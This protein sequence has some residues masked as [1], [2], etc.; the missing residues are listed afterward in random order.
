MD[1]TRHFVRFI[2]LCDLFFLVF[3]S[4][5]VVFSR[6]KKSTHFCGLL[7]ALVRS[8][9]DVEHQVVRR[10]WTLVD[11]YSS[12]VD[13]NPACS[14]EKKRK[15]EVYSTWSETQVSNQ[16]SLAE[17]TSLQEI[18]SFFIYFRYSSSTENSF[19]CGT[20]KWNPEKVRFGVAKPHPQLRYRII[21]EFFILN[22]IVH[23]PQS[24]SFLEIAT[25]IPKVR[26]LSRAPE[27]D[28]R[29]HFNI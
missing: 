14:P 11:I 1:H 9:E 18:T 2:W 25:P 23:E 16:T 5:G 22:I 20:L 8:S 28:L 7:L 6:F 10:R 26:Q 29:L 21:P 19:R 27:I 15:N 12:Q 4:I 3:G 13:V 17:A 24:N